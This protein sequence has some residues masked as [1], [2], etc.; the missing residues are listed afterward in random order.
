MLL[1]VTV[2]MVSSCTGTGAATDAGRD[3]GETPFDAYECLCE[4]V[5]TRP[6]VAA[7]RGFHLEH[8]ENSLAALRAAAMAGAFFVE[9]DV[10]P[11]RDE[12]LVLMHDEDVDRTTD[13]SGLLEQLDWEDV[14]AARLDG[15]DPADPESLLVPRF[16]DTLALSAEL[17][18]MLY[19]DVKTDRLDLVLTAIQA[20]PYRQ[21]A[22]LRAGLEDCAWLKEQ[23]PGVMLLPPA[24]DAAALESAQDAVG[25][26]LIV[27]ME[28]GAADPAFVKLASDAGVKV[29][30]DVFFPGDAKALYG[31]YTGW[32]DYVEA[33]V[34]LLQTEYPHLLVPA[35]EAY[36]DTGVFP[37]EGPG[38]L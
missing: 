30:Q 36:L 38:V 20:G 25:P 28:G 21:V 35:I 37:P 6:L 12:V 23:D 9:V 11:T 15:G 19:V 24:S 7:H 14:Q 10:R 26:L 32:R 16:S 18:V 22:L 33:G 17:G 29:Q 27:E 31:D 13:A 3:P 4:P 8:P 1:P 2:W 34:F 5:C